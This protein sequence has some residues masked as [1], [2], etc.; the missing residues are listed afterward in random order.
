MNNNTNN[1]KNN[2]FNIDE[3]HFRKPN[4]IIEGG[5]KLNNGDRK[6]NIERFLKE[7]NDRKEAIRN[8]NKFI[9][10]SLVVSSKSMEKVI[11]I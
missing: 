9:N 1:S 4:S 5:E 6:P 2:K 8:F 7:A 11:Q 3:K 10:K